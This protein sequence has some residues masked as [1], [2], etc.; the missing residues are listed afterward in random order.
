MGVDVQ[1]GGGVGV[2]QGALHGL[3]IIPGG[4]R[5]HGIGVPLWHNRDK[6][7]KPLRCNGLDGLP[8]FFFH[9]FSPQK[10]ALTRVA[11]KR[12]VPLRTNGMY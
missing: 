11:K 8:L 4:K 1:R 6:S 5:G 3:D 9:L 2:A 7:D 10:Q 12:G